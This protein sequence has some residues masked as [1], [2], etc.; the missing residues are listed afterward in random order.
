MGQEDI[1]VAEI[2]TNL[3]ISETRENVRVAEEFLAAMKTRDLQAIAK[4]LHPQLH[5]IGP[6]GETRGRESF[7][8]TMNQ[9]FARLEKVD[10]T[11]RFTS[12]DQTAYV[13]NMFFA[14][15][16]GP[17]LAASVVT[18]AEGKIKRVEMIYDSKALDD[19]LKQKK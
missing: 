14:A 6:T 1:R 11:A 13:Y 10:M 16:P 17:T 19:V 7:L 4:N 18:H 15:P 8:E 12:G 3:R 9:V 2:Q 5:Y